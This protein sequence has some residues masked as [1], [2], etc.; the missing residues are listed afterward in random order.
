MLGLLSCS[1]SVAWLRNDKKMG[2]SRNPEVSGGN[3]HAVRVPFSSPVLLKRQKAAP[4]SHRK[5]HTV[6]LASGEMFAP[7]LNG[8]QDL[9]PLPF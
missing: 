7:P 9:S 8:R 3:S 4:P 6:R 1:Q 2:V 5:G